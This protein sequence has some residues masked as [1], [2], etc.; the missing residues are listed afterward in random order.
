MQ[1]NPNHKA[2]SDIIEEALNKAITMHEDH[3]EGDIV[4]DWV[5]ISFVTNVDSQKQSAY[6]MF[7]SNG[8]MPEYRARGLLA[9]GLV[10]LT[11]G[12]ED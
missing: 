6:P 11:E 10:K 8:I 1:P 7:L 5:L 9:T 2:T 12:E 4:V 3:E